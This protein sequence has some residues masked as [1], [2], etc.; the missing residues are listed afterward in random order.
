[1]TQREIAK[2][3]G[4]SYSYLNEILKGKKGCSYVLMMEILKYYPNLKNDFHLLNPR[5]ILRKRDV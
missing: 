2:K 3:L 1:M 4:I 5:Y